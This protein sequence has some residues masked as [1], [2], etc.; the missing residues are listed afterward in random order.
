M[1]IRRENLHIFRDYFLPLGSLATCYYP[2]ASGIWNAYKPI[3]TSN[4]TS[5]Y[6]IKSKL[7]AVTNI[8]TNYISLDSK[9]EKSK[10]HLCHKIYV[11]KAG[12]G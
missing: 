8:I 11:I 7:V 1:A 10:C 4:K 12:V 6:N 2:F 9:S 5:C 3:K